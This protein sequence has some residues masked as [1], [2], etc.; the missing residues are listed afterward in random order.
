MRAT[1]VMAIA[2]V[3]YVIKRWATPG[4]TAVN[5]Q[6]VVGGAFAILV[7]AML[8]QGETEEIAQGFAWIFLFLAAYQAIGPIAKVATTKAPGSSGT[9]PVLA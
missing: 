5:T 7:I 9:G 2:V 1:T 4:E 8:D 3:L 6:A